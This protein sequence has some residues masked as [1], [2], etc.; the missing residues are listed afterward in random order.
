MTND[1]LVLVYDRTG[2]KIDS[3]RNVFM[4]KPIG[5]ILQAIYFLDLKFYHR[6][7]RLLETYDTFQ[8]SI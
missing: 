1:A 6:T 5:M 2:K 7:F 8:I 3:N 4:L